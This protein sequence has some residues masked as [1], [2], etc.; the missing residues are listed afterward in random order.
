LKKVN[1]IEK[2]HTMYKISLI[3][4]LSAFLLTYSFSQST[5]EHKRFIKNI[6]EESLTAHHTHQILQQLCQKFPRRLS[7]SK[8][9]EDAVQWAKSLMEG[10]NF[11]N[12]FLQNVLV[13]HWVRG[14]KESAYFYN[15]KGKKENLTILALGRSIATPVD[16]ISAQII[17]VASLEEIPQLGKEKIEGK[18]VYISKPFAQHFIR[19]FEGYSETVQIRSKGPSEAAKYGALACIIRSVGT[20]DD[21]YAHTGGLRYAVNVPQIPAAA[22]SVKSAKKLERALQHNPEVK[23]YLKINSNT[24]PDKMSHNVIGEIKGSE[25][26][27]KIIVIAGH[28]DAWDVGQGA[29]DDGAGCMQSVMAV[30]MLQQMGYKPKNTL[31]VVLFTNEE[32]GIKGGKKYAELA[33]KNKEDHIFAL[34]SD[35]GGFTPR[36]IGIKGPDSL[37]QNLS[38]WIKF[39]PDFTIDKIVM[40]DGGADVSPLNKET[41]TPV[42]GLLPDSQRY[43]DFH[44]THADV[45][46]AV[47]KRELEMGT[48]SMASF[49]YLVDQLGL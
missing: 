47:N 45:F 3:L 2:E 33:V 38:S 10:Y 35:A 9:L 18:I 17:Q 5:D 31:R 48:A 36:A 28:L 22:L 34:E 16:G 32:N 11:D 41:G 25:N 14:E 13:P 23:F 42:G 43:F 49:I 24:L 44:H 27:Q 29:H 30:R 12:V 40:G 7:G 46:E 6:Y 15:S 4:I 19:T 1:R 39:F 26:P 21:D 37:V 8:G 20:A